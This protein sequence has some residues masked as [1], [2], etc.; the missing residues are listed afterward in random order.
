MKYISDG[1]GRN[2][3]YY[4]CQRACVHWIGSRLCVK[5]SSKCGYKQNCVLEYALYYV[6]HESIRTRLLK[7]KNVTFCFFGQRMYGLIGMK[8]PTFI[9]K[10]KLH[11]ILGNGKLNCQYEAVTLQCTCNKR[12]LLQMQRIIAN[13]CRYSGGG[14]HKQYIIISESAMCTMSTVIIKTGKA[15]RSTVAVAVYNSS[16]LGHYRN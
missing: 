12:K 1:S 8:K 15:R 6:Y 16:K 7:F 11:A 2:V 10:P 14:S 3:R 4:K 13:M 9:W 5:S